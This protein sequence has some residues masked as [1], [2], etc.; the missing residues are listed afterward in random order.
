MQP[1]LHHRR[2][3]QRH[4]QLFLPISLLHIVHRT[5]EP[6]RRRPRRHP[7]RQ[8]RPGGRRCCPRRGFNMRAG[9]DRRSLASSSPVGEQGHSSPVGERR[10]SPVGEQGQD[11]LSSSKRRSSPVGEQ[12]HDLREGDDHDCLRAVSRRNLFLKKPSSYSSCGGSNE[13]QMPNQSHGV[14]EHP[15]ESIVAQKIADRLRHQENC[16]TV[17]A[18]AIVIVSNID[19]ARTYLSSSLDETRTATGS[20][21]ITVVLV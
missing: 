6:Q 5:Q 16:C 9:D 3:Y 20:Q 4:C 13:T 11:F 2:P 15:Q 19:P 17:A 7:P 14:I 12:G 18:A 21:E 8:R 10:S 1:F